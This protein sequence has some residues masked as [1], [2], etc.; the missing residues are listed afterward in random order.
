[1]NKYLFPIYAI[2]AGYI[3]VRF[4]SK[5]TLINIKLLLAFSGAFLLSQTVFILIPEVY[6]SLSGKLTG[7]LIM[8]GILVQIFLE[9]FSKGAEHGHIHIHSEQ[10]HFPWL[11]FISLCVHAFLEGFPVTQH[12]DLVYGILIHKIPIAILITSYL[13]NSKFKDLEVIFFLFV[14]AIMTPLGTYISNEVEVS[15]NYI[16]M[17]NAVVIGI[18]LHISTIILFESSEGHKFNLSKLIVIVL[19][20]ALAYLI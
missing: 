6:E 3:L 7:A 10:T 15:A 18:F 13:L 20:V 19:A 9:F 1:M 5:R 16:Q 17:I 8:T 4:A 11:L 2:I 12:N 14:F